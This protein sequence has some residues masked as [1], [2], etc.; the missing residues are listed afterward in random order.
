MQLNTHANR[1]KQIQKHV[2]AAKERENK[3]TNERTC[4]HAENN[5]NRRTKKQNT[6]TY[7]RGK[8]L[9]RK[10]STQKNKQAN[11]QTY[12]HEGKRQKKQTLQLVDFASTTVVI[13]VS[14]TIKTTGKKHTHTC[15]ISDS[16][17]IQNMQ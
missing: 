17:S 13:L 3:Q 16:I 1:T 2:G 14:K 6:Y 8:Q 15:R 11:R 7:T 4:G 12:K 9:K 5:E 10:A